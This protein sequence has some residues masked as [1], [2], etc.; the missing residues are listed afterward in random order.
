MRTKFFYWLGCLCMAVAFVSCSSDD[1]EEVG[2]D[3]ELVG[4]WLQIAEEGWY[5]EDGVIVDEWDEPDDSNIYAYFYKDGTGVVKEYG[6]S[7]EFTWSLSSNK[8]TVTTYGETGTAT[9]KT[10]NSTTLIIESKDKYVDEG[11]TCEEYTLQT[12][13]RVKE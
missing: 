11:V 5:K 9:V 13:K 1:D 2:S 10:L 7:F 3:N 6:M 8:L 12:Y 4:C